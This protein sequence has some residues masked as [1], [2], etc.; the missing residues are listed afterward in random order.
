MI[1]MYS[2]I[3]DTNDDYNNKNFNFYI[4]FLFL[5]G[6]IYMY[7][8]SFKILDYKSLYNFN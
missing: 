7:F 1:K 4:F 8:Y 3:I 6:F 5:F 2:N